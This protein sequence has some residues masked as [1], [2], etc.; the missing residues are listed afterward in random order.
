MAGAEVDQMNL[1]LTINNIQAGTATVSIPQ[2]GVAET[3]FDLTTGLTGRNKALIS[4]NDF[5]V[6][7]DNEF[8]LALNFTDKINIL[9]I[10]RARSPLP[11]NAFSV[12]KKYLIS[13]VL[14]SAILI[15]ACF[16][17]PTW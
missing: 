16:H 17:K 12:I 15:T 4:F 7:F 6:S 8:Y 13:K 1:K 9:E 3:N 10:N 5:P 2:R 11:W 14:R